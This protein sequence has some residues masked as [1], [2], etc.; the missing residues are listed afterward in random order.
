MYKAI[1]EFVLDGVPYKPGQTVDVSGI[2]PRTV[3][4]LVEQRNL[5]VAP[6]APDAKRKAA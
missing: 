3:A 4:R 5:M 2:D 6:V 1:N